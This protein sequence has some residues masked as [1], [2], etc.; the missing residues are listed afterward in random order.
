ME[1]FQ[2]WTCEW[3]CWQADVLSFDKVMV[4]LVTNTGSKE[5]DL[6]FHMPTM[7]F[8]NSPTGKIDPKGCFG[9]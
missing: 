9:T 8:I 2:K 1:I 4:S 5:K 7:P 3:K 6:V